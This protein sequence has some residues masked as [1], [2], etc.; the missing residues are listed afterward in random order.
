[1][2]P[3]RMQERLSRVAPGWLLSTTVL[4]VHLGL[5]ATMASTRTTDRATL[6]RGHHQ[7][8]QAASDGQEPAFGPMVFDG[9]SEVVAAAAAMLLKGGHQHGSSSAA[10]AVDDGAQPVFPERPDAVY[11]AVAVTGGAKLWGR[12]LA[13]TL[14]DMGPPF[15]NPQ[16]PP[17][18][19]I[20]IDLPDNGRFSSKLMSGA[21]DAID[22]MPL[23]GM[24]IVGD[25]S[26][27]KALALAGNAMKI[28]VL[29]AKGGTAVLHNSYDELSTKLQAI[30]Q[31]SSREIFESIRATLLQVHWHSYHILCDV[32]TSVLISGKKGAALRQ[33]PLNPMIITVPT[34]HDLIYKKLAYISRS[35]KGVVL[36]LSNL[37]VARL[38]MAEAQRMKML[39]GH[40]VW[41]WMDTTSAT[42]F[43]E[44]GQYGSGGG[45]GGAGGGAPYDTK[46]ALDGVRSELETDFYDTFDLRQ[47]S[48]LADLVERRMEFE[49]FESRL[50]KN[51]TRG[52]HLDG[53]AARFAASAALPPNRG[54]FESGKAGSHKG[55]KPKLE[56]LKSGKTDRNTGGLLP[57]NTVVNVAKQQNPD[58]RF[59]DL[60]AEDS[61]EW[62]DFDDDEETIPLSLSAAY[63]DGV[64]PV[65]KI[66]PD[67][68]PQTGQET[69]PKRS[70]SSSS[71]GI[72]GGGGAYLKPH[73]A[74]G[75]V[76]Y[77]HSQE[78]PVGLLALRP[79]RMKID[80][81]FIRAAVRLFAS[82][83]AKVERE[84]APS[85]GPPKGRGGSGMSYTGSGSRG[86]PWHEPAT[87]PRGNSRPSSSSSSSSSSAQKR[88]LLDDQ[89]G[90]PRILTFPVNS[91]ANAGTQQRVQETSVVSQSEAVPTPG[92]VLGHD[93]I[94]ISSP[95]SNSSAKLRDVRSTNSSRVKRQS[96]W[97]STATT[98]QRY[99]TERANAERGGGRAR[100]AGA[101]RYKGGCMGS[102]NRVEQAKAFNFARN[103]QLN[104][105][106]ALSGFAIA[107]GYIEKSL[108]SHFEILNLV[109]TDKRQS[110]KPEPSA[111][112]AGSS[113]TEAGRHWNRAGNLSSA[114]VTG[115]TG[116][117]WR[118]VGLITGRSV[119][120]DTIIW[121][122]GDVTV[123]G[124]TGKAKTKFRVVVSVAP[125][126]VMESPVNE[127][128]Q[129]LRGLVC[130]KIFTTGRHNLTLMFNEIE[131]RN[132]LRDIDPTVSLF[133]EQQQTYHLYRV[134]CC[135]GLSMDLLQ[136][137]AAEINF[138]YHL[139]IVHDGLFGRRVPGSATTSDGQPTIQPPLIRPTPPVT[140]ESKSK[141]DAQSGRSLKRGSK[142]K[143]TQTVAANASDESVDRYP[144]Q[145]STAPPARTVQ[146]WNGV[147]GDLIS[148]TADLS[149]APLSV[150]KARSEVIDFTIPY[151]HGGVSLLAAPET[152][153]D[154]PLL[155]FLLPFSPELWIAIFTSLNVTAV[156]VAIYEW[157][158]P[159][160]LNPWGRQRSKNFSMSSA[161]WV[162]WG[163]L[164]GHL[165]AFKAP[166]SWPNKF[167]INVW[168]GFSVIFIA[169]YTANIAALIAGLLFH[170]EAK[171]YEM[172]MLTQRVGSPIAT[173]AESYVQYN[174][175][176]LW[177]H[178]KKYQLHSI[179]E[180]IQRLKNR[181][182]DL[183]M[184][185]TPILDYY[186]GTDQSCSLQRIGD[187]Y[188]EDSY[189]I[190]MSKGFPLKQTMSMLISK[191][192]HDGYLDI[193][194]AKWYGDLPC[195]KLDREMAQPK[196]LGVTAVAGV[197][198]LLG[199]GMV[200]GVL[201]LII[202]HVFYKYTL[203]ILRHQPKDTIWKS[204]NIMFFSQ[205]LYRFI[206]CVELV[207]PHHAAKELVHTIRQGQITSLFQKSVKREDEQR[208]R[209]K[210]KAQFFEMIQEIRS[211]T[212]K[213]RNM[214][215]DRVQLDPDAD[216]SLSATSES[217]SQALLPD[218]S[219]SAGGGGGRALA[220]SISASTSRRASPGR[221]RTFG[222]G[223]R[224]GAST[225]KSSSFGSSLNVRRFSTDSIISERLGTIGR[226]LSRDAATSS[227]PDLTHHFETFG[228]GGG[229][230]GTG[231]AS[232]SKFDTYSGKNNSKEQ[233]AVFKCDTYNGK[234]ETSGAT[235]TDTVDG[236]VKADGPEEKPALPV[237]TKKRSRRSPLN[238]ELY[239]SSRR[240][241]IPISERVAHGLAPPFLEADNGSAL[242][243]D[244]LHEELRLKYG[245]TR[246]KSASQS[247]ATDG[248]SGGVMQGRAPM[249]VPSE[250]TNGT[251]EQ[252][253]GSSRRQP[254]TSSRR[255]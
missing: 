105:R 146:Q 94:D 95:I 194:T 3:E 132:R 242:L 235:G 244:K 186:R 113:G 43:Y 62:L 127:E 58:H 153:S 165:V 72:G 109:P 220:S 232:S 126:F 1:M 140:V 176:P 55:S 180:G 57:N 136:K 222:F 21:C 195:F 213:R 151:F 69:K 167:L 30:L 90:V 17:L 202:E 181:T 217:T 12:T 161:L 188:I 24:V 77:H 246:W 120:L 91:S 119:H 52:S 196:P 6:V 110:S 149:F 2:A 158:S 239:E 164:C 238:L 168:G 203:P 204:R 20:Y 129:C 154:I 229:G 226:R 177:E 214:K 104:T 135:Y 212:L 73:N 178:M 50:R 38:I 171:Y 139:Y 53:H 187:N 83:W 219:M 61:E 44:T 5:V 97:W 85:T 241:L 255:K 93:T 199:V 31:P 65:E 125:P 59:D 205:K 88:S 22:G 248:S 116:T 11:F 16:G 245:Q 138:D 160:G 209:R 198:L 201:I 114:T 227:P 71:S 60:L 106:Q 150:S 100:G 147:I 225:S 102:I 115:G 63:D 152:A 134:R 156:A 144:F 254:S 197:F 49:D 200:L 79:I 64:T 124:L 218:A 236:K 141:F 96:T 206:N 231:G 169:S 173:A 107:S 33:K 86:Q 92:R 8:Q 56:R 78:F 25:S 37:K 19:P 47:Q 41:L 51:R 182:I 250:E 208:R 162:M 101:T 23:A 185:D 74:S 99:G 249:P 35:T 122:G 148:G 233:I 211:C 103:L 68:E 192:S 75:H 251:V 32:D 253:P 108:V 54:P 29:W 190:G 117:K 143:G 137:L 223:R 76:L 70:S 46:Q 98:N 118:R 112:E 4:F 111:S 163:L 26:S 121:P 133:H 142:L 159:F 215:L 237:K 243:R 224:E 247:N 216:A 210:S 36:V 15:G 10:F 191:Y 128:G 234:L 18:R 131:R 179:D 189:A 34:N 28:P 45:G 48:H 157:L 80:R 67:L 89:R 230:D 155:A 130:Y 172:S 7:Q 13:R 40:F 9:S 221:L 252:R 184:C 240:R 27:A 39:N 170:N 175:K 207:S 87:K 82:T 166:K 42:E 193:L 66:D 84:E 174:D 183:L 228:K 14:I 145:Y 81:H 123:S